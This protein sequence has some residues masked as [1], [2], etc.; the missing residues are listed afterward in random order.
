MCEI[1]FIHIFYESNSVVVVVFSSLG[2]RVNNVLKNINFFSLM[3]F[4]NVSKYT[5]YGISW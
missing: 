5:V 4:E 3:N 1:Y 2:K